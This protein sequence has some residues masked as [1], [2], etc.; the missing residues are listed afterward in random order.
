MILNWWC[1]TMHNSG[2][3]VLIP[4]HTELKNVEK[5]NALLRK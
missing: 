2:K 5:Q 1:R 3:L 4:G